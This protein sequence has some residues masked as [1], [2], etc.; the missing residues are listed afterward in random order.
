VAEG[1][2]SA[3]EL[4]RFTGTFVLPRGGGTFVIERHG[5]GLR[6]SG[7]GLQASA[8]VAQGCWPP[9]NEEL[10]R[11]HED[12]G[13]RLV[14][15]LL[16]DAATADAEAFTAA[17]NG[18]TARDLLR[19]WKKENGAPV[20]IEYVGSVMHQAGESWYRLRTATKQLVLHAV[21]AH[22]LKWRSCEVATEAPPFWV[23]LKAQGPDCAV[24]ATAERRQLV[25]TMEG[26]VASRC[27]VFE[28][29]SVGNGGV[30]ECKLAD[31]VPR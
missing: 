24:A 5:A 2:F 1:E 29:A 12:R 10:L 30:I 14:E 4:A 21:W 3:A 8:R 18:T 9:P 7:W 16:A 27:L 28:D 20:A 25:L 6:L 19:A 31:G 22:E 15:L 13:L 26:P 23:D 17:S 11:R